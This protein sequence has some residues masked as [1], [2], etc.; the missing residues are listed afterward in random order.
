MTIR[1]A[2]R[3]MRG[4]AAE[5]RLNPRDADLLLAEALG[6]SVEWLL[7]HDD[8]EI[9]AGD[10]ESYV[11]LL[12][13]RFA[14]EPL[15]YIRGRCEFYGR[16]FLVDRRTLIPRPE[17]EHLVESAVSLIPRDG[18]IIDIGTGSGCIAVT[19]AL[20]R[21]D[22]AV[23]ATDISVEA[24]V[25]AR[26]NAVRLGA[27]VGFAVADAVE[28]LRGPFDAIL[29]NPPY[30]PQGEMPYLQR[31][32]REHEPGVAL[33]PGGDGLGIVRQLIWQTPALLTRDGLFF[34]EIGYQQRDAVAELAKERGWGSIRFVDDLA[35][36][37]RMALLEGVPA[38]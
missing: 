31:E 9:A 32:V 11:D 14:G 1:E 34:M 10:Y 30:I 5:R 21:P 20:E 28:P 37:P 18:R 12:R 7:A 24:V 3:E 33:S 25:A 19:V 4:E 36:I 26:E 13:R 8:E 27:A 23:F 17:T 29:S 22:L 35:T 15:Q 6:R 2:L 38:D 16:E